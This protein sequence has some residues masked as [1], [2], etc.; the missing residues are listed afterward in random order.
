[1][2]TDSD[3][4]YHVLNF[5]GYTYILNQ[6]NLI[7]NL[8]TIVVTVYILIFVPQRIQMA[9]IKKHVTVIILIKL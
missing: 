8:I 7:L 2:C 1:M 3:R 9:L 4:I 6:F 5:R